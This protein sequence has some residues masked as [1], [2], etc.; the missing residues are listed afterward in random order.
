MALSKPL[1]VDLD[2]ELLNEQLSRTNLDS[3]VSTDD[4]IRA[5]DDYLEGRTISEDEFDNITADDLKMLEADD[6]P[7]ITKP[8]TRDWR[9]PVLLQGPAETP[10]SPVEHYNVDTDITAFEHCVINPVNRIHVVDTTYDDISQDDSVSPSPTVSPTPADDPADVKPVLYC[11]R[12]YGRQEYRFRSHTSFYGIFTTPYLAGSLQT[13]SQ[14]QT[15]A[16]EALQLIK[17]TR[18]LQFM[19]KIINTTISRP[20]IS[21]IC[22]S[23]TQ[24]HLYPRDYDNDAVNFRIPDPWIYTDTVHIAYSVVV[25]AALRPR[26]RHESPHPMRHPRVDCLRQPVVSPPPKKR[27]RSK[28]ILPP[29]GLTRASK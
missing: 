20:Q 11:V 17:T 6:E 28:G 13:R 19:D 21:Y 14:F 7:G 12:V 5:I 8:G 4:V 16:S 15:F 27:R 26:V 23:G 10:K 9:S 3:N 29:S 1:P 24:V 18:P 22:R 25:H 2:V